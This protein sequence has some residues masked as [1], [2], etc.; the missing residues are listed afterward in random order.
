MLGWLFGDAK[1]R[2]EENAKWRKAFLEGLPAAK[3][4]LYIL[5]DKVENK[6]LRYLV[7]SCIEK[8]DDEALKRYLS[9]IVIPKVSP[10]IRE[11]LKNLGRE[12]SWASTH[13]LIQAGYLHSADNTPPDSIILGFVS[14]GDRDN[15]CLDFYGEGHLLTVARTGAGKGQAHV[16]PTLI[17]YRGPAVVLD[18]KGEAYRETAWAR[19][20]YGK[21]FKWAPFE[22]E[23]DAFNPLDMVDDWEDAKDLAKL[24]VI[25]TSRDP[26][27]DISAQSL[28]AATVIY[29]K[30]T[31]P[32]DRQTMREVTRALSPDPEEFDAFIAEM[33]ASG[34][35][36][37]EDAAKQFA[38]LGENLRASVY[39]SAL[40]HLE[41]WRSP[42]I[43]RATAFSTFDFHPLTLILDQYM[44][45]F[46]IHLGMHGDA[47]EIDIPEASNT[48][49]LIVP[50]DR[51]AACQSVLRVILGMMLYG[52]TKATRSIKMQ[53]IDEPDRD[54]LDKLPKK[55]VLFM[56]DELPQLGYVEA[57]ERAA[58]IGRS[59]KIRLWLFAQSINQL[60]NMY[61]RAA[62]IIENCR[63][64][65]FFGLSELESATYVAEIIGKTRSLWG[66]EDWVVTPQDLMGS[67]EFRERQI[68]F[69]AGTKPVKSRL[70]LLY[71]DDELQSYV[72]DARPQAR[73][74]DRIDLEGRYTSNKD[75][76]AALQE[77]RKQSRAAEEA[78][79]QKQEKKN[80]KENHVAQ[81]TTQRQEATPPEPKP[82]PPPEKQDF[83]IDDPQSFDKP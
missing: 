77:L 56:L 27:W 18:L 26:F 59:S 23:T 62:S 38:G 79:R 48:F 63:A 51:V 73:P 75:E 7:R 40:S 72:Q 53:N 30:K 70:R 78:A 29:I 57:V 9:E 74:R 68:V 16:L 45:D 81:A 12:S 6:D 82:A 19:R 76:P 10:E 28:I 60:E 21:V 20:D 42:A 65:M 43:T 8:S 31:R 80:L 33:R 39:Q 22:E 2:R 11:Q 61:P 3:R 66:E 25:P 83:G 41:A 1:K 46:N 67:A 37:L 52:V 69:L 34:D 54:A 4:E 58:E 49:F 44:R 64:K 32:A 17:D 50:E 35:E 5:M 71:K 55:P 36:Y 47:K 15:L 24:L 14:H 13:E